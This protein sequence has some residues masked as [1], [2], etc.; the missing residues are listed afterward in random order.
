MA[1]EITVTHTVEP[2]K[3]P[4]PSRLRRCDCGEVLT[5]IDRWC[6]TACHRADEPGAYEDDYYEEDES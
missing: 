4:V 2:A 5:G 6:S 3:E 1:V